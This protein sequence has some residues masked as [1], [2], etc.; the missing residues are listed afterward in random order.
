V[1]VWKHVFDHFIE[2][3]VQTKRLLASALWQKL[4]AALQDASLDPRSERLRRPALECAA[5]LANDGTPGGAGEGLQHGIKEG[6]AAEAGSAAPKVVDVNIW[7]SK[8]DPVTSEQCS[9]S[10]A[11]IRRL[12]EKAST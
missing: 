6:A 11:A 2:E 12:E 3:K 8:L 9:K 5:S 7:V 10:I 4:A 1:R